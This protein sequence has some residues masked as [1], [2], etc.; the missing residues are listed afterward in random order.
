MFYLNFFYSFFVFPFYLT[1]SFLIFKLNTL[2]SPHAE[3]K[4]RLILYV[5]SMASIMLPETAQSTVARLS[6]EDRESAVAKT[7]HKFLSHFW[8]QESR[9]RGEVVPAYVPGVLTTA[10]RRA[11][12]L[13]VLKACLTTV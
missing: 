6:H 2:L 9:V 4:G 12:M 1:C 5:Q 8:L 7:N 11:K 13:L 10:V 3:A